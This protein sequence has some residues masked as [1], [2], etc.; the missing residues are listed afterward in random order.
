MTPDHGPIRQ[1]AAE[2]WSTLEGSVKRFEEAWHRGL[3]PAIDDYLPPGEKPRQ[4]LLV[5][6]VHTDLELRLKAKEAAR[7]EEYLARYPELDGRRTV[8][9]GL[10]AAEFG[11][12]QRGESNPPFDEYLLRFPR[13]RAELE[14]EIARATVTGSGGGEPMPRWL[15][16]GRQEVIPEVAGY[17]ILEELGRGGMGVVYK[18]RQVRLNRFV[19]LKMILAGDHAGPEA[20]VRFLAEAEAVGRLRHPNIVQIHA[21]GDQDGRPYFE[22]EYVAGGSL[23]DRLDGAPWPTRDAA[24]LVETLSLAIH[25]AH[26]LGIVHRDLKPANVLLNEDGTPKVA[27]FGLAKWMDVESG[28]TR[29]DHVL[30]SPSYMA[31]EQAE[32]GGTHVGPAAD[33][34]ALGAILYELIAGRPPFRAATVLETLEQV[35][36]AEPIPPDRL[37]PGLPRDLATIC[38]KCL[39]KDPTKR[40][41]GA[42]ALGEDLRRFAAGEPIRARPVSGVERAWRWCRREPTLTALASLVALLVLVVAV[43]APVAVVSLRRQ[44]DQARLAEQSA[45]AKL[46]QSHLDRARANRLSGRAGQRFESLRSLALAASIRP[47]PELRDEAIACLALTDLN[48][49]RE[50]EGYPHLNTGLDF[51]ARLERYARSDADGNISVRSVDDD[52]EILRLP[53]PAPRSPAGRLAFSPDGRFLAATYIPAGGREHR[54][55]VWDLSRDRMALDIPTDLPGV[56]LAFSPD[57]RR[58][59][60]G[61]PNHFMSIY[62][63][64]TLKEVKRLE[65]LPDLAAVGFHPRGQLMAISSTVDRMVQVRDSDTGS[66]VA[67][68]PH[69]QCVRG[70]AWSGDG[71]TLAAGCDDHQIY[72]W[73]VGT[74]RLRAVLSGH[75]APVVLIA[76]HPSDDL[77]ASASWD[78]TS[79]LWDP[80]RGKQLASAQGHVLRFSSDG[81]RLAYVSAPRVG[82]WEVAGRDSF[83]LLQPN[84]AAGPPREGGPPGNFHV[85]TSPLG[86]LLAASALDGVRLWDLTAAREVAHLPVGFSGAVLFHPRDGS[87]ITYG[88]TG[89]ERWPIRPDTEV[90]TGKLR[91]GPSTKLASFSRSDSYHACLG[92][93]G[94]LLAVADQPNQQVIVLDVDRP[95]DRTQFGNQPGISSVALSPDSRWVAASSERG[96]EIKVWDRASGQLVAQLPDS[97][98]E[99]ANAYVA[100]SPDGRCLVTGSQDQYR[101]WQAGSWQLAWTIR[102]DRLEEMPGPFAFTRDGRLL[103]ITPAPCRVQLIETATRRLI[104]N[105]SAPDPKLIRDICFDAD[106]SQLAVATDEP[107]IQVWDL[108]QVGRELVA[109]GLDWGLEVS[110]GIARGQ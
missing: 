81:A 12:R 88:A 40:Y 95:A 75:D 79:R 35:K 39:R 24:R 46:W 77:L 28:L 107:A 83:R 33:V 97:T 87:L 108:R 84:W 90:A 94:G 98:A 64:D 80:V 99:T 74:F 43:G 109:M 31:P 96:P 17:E 106:G 76:F 55:R 66:L 9:L 41:A 53:A 52:S 37:Q 16:N 48:T 4:S 22:M 20:A 49:L 19:A 72:L 102:R 5:E 71:G 42:L 56:R 60:I 62:D 30:G 86:P 65:R 104:A 6:L 101:F 7:V 32:G 57:S 70:L 11:L 58:V 21:F 38:L 63:L 105:F 13:F 69:P 78:G 73:D 2:Q 29:T 1:A 85:A 50:W 10:I 34:Y 47:A 45:T 59:A 67:T 68:L 36:L 100:F 15:R 18:A 93:D 103:A 26:R 27:D 92:R 51:D 82:V 44:R 14:E 91:V 89:V 61:R 8:V 23:A 25:E 3:R 54:H 110:P